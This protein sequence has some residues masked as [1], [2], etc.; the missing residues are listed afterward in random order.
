MLLIALCLP[1]AAAQDP[2]FYPDVGPETV[3]LDADGSLDGLP[4]RPTGAVLAQ[5]ADPRVLAA[6]PQIA[7]VQHLRG[8]RGVVRLWP[9]AGI[10]PFALSRALHDRA[11]VAWAHPDLA[12]RLVPHGLPDDPLLADQWHLD[13]QGQNGGTPT[14]DIHAFDAWERAWGQGIRVAVLDTG[15]DASHP[16]LI[17]TSGHDYISSDEDSDPE[18]EAHGTAAAGLA[19]ATGNNGIGV[20]GVAWGGDVY[21]IRLIG[22]DTTLGDVYDAF[23][24]SVD[25]GAAVI[26]NSWGYGGSCPDIP[27][28]ASMRTAFEYA[29]EVGREGLGTAVVFSAGNEGCDHSNNLMLAHPAVTAVSATN[30]RD[31]LE[32]YSTY[33]EIVDIAGPSGGVLTTDISGDAGYGDYRGDRDYTPGFSGT[34]ASAPIVSGVLAVMFSANADL[35]ASEARTVLCQTATRI[36]PAGGRYDDRGWSP[37]YGCGRPDLA[38]AVN[39][40]ANDAPGAVSLL[41]PLD[42]ADSPRPLLQWAPAADAD[43]DPLAYSVRWWT[44]ELT[45]DEDEDAARIHTDVVSWGTSLDIQDAV[46]EGEVVSWSVQATDAWATGPESAVWTFTV[47]P[48]PSRPPDTGAADEEAD[49]ETDTDTRPEPATGCSSLPGAP[50]GLWLAGALALGARRRRRQAVN[51]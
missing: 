42:Q 30:H 8:D 1:I 37:L 4:V 21:A 43:A 14:A 36:D 9:Q 31:Q 7:Q 25:A 22:G 3:A 49:T 11:D 45:G 29:D 34:S 32:S 23:A 44:G 40:V 46:A 51:G 39:A 33:G 17:V 19:V 5:V 2:W 12:M 16:D 41:S 27:L 26:S 28:F 38:A 15:V 13:N 47:A 24:E 18:G 35:T 6:M 48:P 20:A 10:D 50:G